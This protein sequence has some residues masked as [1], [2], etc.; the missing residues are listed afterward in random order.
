M[1]GIFIANLVVHYS[2]NCRYSN[3]I[4]Q[5]FNRTN[6]WFG[7]IFT[8]LFACSHEHVYV[9]ALLSAWNKPNLTCRWFPC[10]GH[11]VCHPLYVRRYF[12]YIS[13]MRCIFSV[14]SSPISTKGLLASAHSS[15]SRLWISRKYLT[16]KLYHLRD[17]FREWNI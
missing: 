11:G 10:R 15:S 13:Q 6:D 9:K 5:E 3:T 4:V 17:D 12:Q 7:S 1:A 8:T 16:W 14:R 2:V